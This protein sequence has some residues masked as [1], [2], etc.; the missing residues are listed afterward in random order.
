MARGLGFDVDRIFTVTFALG[1]GLAG[2][3]GAM[4]IEIVGLDPIFALTYLVFM[5]IVVSVGGLGSIA[6]LF[7]A[8][9]PARHQRHRWQILR[10]RAW[11]IPHLSGHGRGT[12][13]AAAGLFGRR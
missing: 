10:A 8:A 9:M 4:A 2:L 1:T 13:V 11:L 5:L 6:G 7:A 3:G 12:D